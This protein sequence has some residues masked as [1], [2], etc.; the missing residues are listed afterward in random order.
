MAASLPKPAGSVS[1]VLPGLNTIYLVLLVRCRLF[2]GSRRFRSALEP[3]GARS[4][5][6]TWNLKLERGLSRATSAGSWQSTWYYLLH[7]QR[8]RERERERESEKKT[9]GACYEV[10]SEQT[11]LHGMLNTHRRSLKTASYNEIKHTHTHKI[12]KKRREEE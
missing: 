6:S 5:L 11:M 2:V 1:K 4:K 12:R 3:D 8:E 10:V 7:T 9:M